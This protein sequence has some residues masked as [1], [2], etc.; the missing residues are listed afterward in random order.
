M[1][2]WRGS[3]RDSRRRGV[4][5]A[6][7]DVPAPRQA[8]A[9]WFTQEHVPIVWL[10]RNADGAIAV[11]LDDGRYT[12]FHVDDFGRKPVWLGPVEEID[13]RGHVVGPATSYENAVNFLSWNLVKR[14]PQRRAAGKNPKQQHLYL[15]NLR[16]D[17]A[18]VAAL[19]NAWPEEW[20]WI[21][22]NEP[23]DAIRYRLDRAAAL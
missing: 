17:G 22:A 20:M 10:G 3:G 13:A 21:I 19:Q 15:L 9:P 16:L 4:P 1:D 5:T 6:M 12:Y 2:A 18:Q 14:G 8:P 11:L 7:P 23:A